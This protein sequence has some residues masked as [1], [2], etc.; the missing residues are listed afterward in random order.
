MLPLISICIPTY[1][2]ADKLKFLLDSIRLQ[3]F[4]D[5]E[6]I[7][8]DDS[9]SDDV[10]L[11]CKSYSD[12]P[13]AYYRN[14]PAKG[15]PENWNYAISLAKG[16]WIKLM[17]HDDYF[18]VPHALA[19]FISCA[20]E[21]EDA[22]F[23]Y[24]GTSILYFT[25]KRKEVYIVDQS[26]LSRIAEIPTY[27]F[28]KNLIGSPSVT[29]FRT[30][31][32]IQF[33][34]Q[35]KWLVDIEA[36]LR[37]LHLKKVF[38]I[39]EVLIETIASESQL[40]EVMRDNPHYELTEYLY[41]YRTH[42]RKSTLINKRILNTRLIILLNQFNIHTKSDLLPYYKNHKIPTTANVYFFLCR[43][44]KRFAFS[45]IYRINKFNLQQQVD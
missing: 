19:T 29:F 45:L 1:N 38:Q 5:F 42:Y 4:R 39:K 44:N 25:S 14:E 7:V 31:D 43:F 13:I 32:V 16:T 21:N 33:D 18:A 2:Q 23:F 10:S 9:D 11:L 41:C 17:H 12:L 8:S 37:F 40:T 6:V 3:T 30:R 34:N 22:E 35:L 24:A 20:D 28:F 36:Y 27:L 26:I 15:S